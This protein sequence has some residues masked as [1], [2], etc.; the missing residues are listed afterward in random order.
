MSRIVERMSAAADNADECGYSAP[1]ALNYQ[2]MVRAALRSVK[3]ED[4]D[5]AVVDAFLR[6]LAGRPPT[7][8]WLKCAIAAAIN[9]AE[10]G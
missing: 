2:N 6:E 3:P 8:P 5:R 7:D 10:G 1:S 4:L 9:A